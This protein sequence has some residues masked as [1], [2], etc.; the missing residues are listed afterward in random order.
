MT[1]NMTRRQCAL[2][3]QNTSGQVTLL[4]SR[5][6]AS[7]CQQPRGKM[8]PCSNEADVPI[9]FSSVR[10]LVKYLWMGTKKQIQIYQNTPRR[11]DARCSCDTYHVKRLFTITHAWFLSRCFVIKHV[12]SIFSCSK[13]YMEVEIKNCKGKRKT[14]LLCRPNSAYRPCSPSTCNY[15]KQGASCEH[16]ALQHHELTQTLQ[17]SLHCGENT[18]NSSVWKEQQNLK[19]QRLVFTLLTLQ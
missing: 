11:L 7:V 13:L 2:Y 1:W 3:L 18:D 17:W 14:N 15:L 12:L 9:I 5:H 4:C 8:G 10:I 19:R 16:Y 6:E